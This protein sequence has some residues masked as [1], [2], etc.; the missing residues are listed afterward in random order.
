MSNQ[1]INPIHSS[2]NQPLLENTTFYDD[3]V[4]I[5]DAANGYAKIIHDKLTPSRLGS[6]MTPADIRLL[7]DV[8][9]HPGDTAIMLR[10]FAPENLR[11]L[12][13][14]HIY[15]C[16][17]WEIVGKVRVIQYVMTPELDD[18]GNTVQVY[19]TFR[20]I[21]EEYELKSSHQ[22]ALRELSRYREDMNRFLSAV[23]CGIIQYTR[24]SKQLIYINEFALNILGYHSKE[25]VLADGFNGI[26]STVDPDD[27]KAIR[28]LI[29]EK[30]INDGD[31][32]TYEYSVHH[33][34]GRPL[35]CYGTAQ[36][37]QRE[38]AEPIIQRSV[39]DITEHRLQMAEREA[40]QR[41][42]VEDALARAEHANRAKTA[43]L[44]SMSHD[45]RTPMNAIIGYTTL[46]ISHLD[47]KEKV[48]DY[49]QKI[50]SSSDHLL[51]LINDVL[52]MSR[53]EAGRVHLQETEESLPE[54]MNDL[55]ELLQNEII[56]KQLHFTYETKNI[57]DQGIYCDQLRLNQILLNCLTNSIKYTPTYGTVSLTVAQIPCESYEHATY[58][59]R[60]K[61]NGIGMSPEFAKHIFEPFTRENTST[62]SGIQGT[63]LGMTIT[64][65][66]VSMM[67]GDITVVSEKGVGTEFIIELTFLKTDAASTSADN[68]DQ[69]TAELPTDLNGIRIL[70]AEDNELNMEIAK[71]LLTEAGAQ[72]DTVDDGSLAVE[73]VRT[74][75]TGQYDIVLMDIQ[76][77]IMDGYTATGAIRALKGNPN[78]SLP[79]LAM[80]ANAFNEDKW[81]AKEAGMNGHLSKP[82]NIADVIRTI[83]E[84]LGY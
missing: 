71:E 46:A 51:A 73:A 8:N 55:R 18:S 75:T 42:L 63:G 79:I 13:V 7:L 44:N 45:I 52:D 27:A 25:E 67:G 15:T 21:R 28:Q 50:Q 84:V 16:R 6:V 35:V 36:L 19:T 53:I 65:N 61:D 80:T 62:V 1:G 40:K 74:A 2:Y 10:D 59:F 31:K 4:W 24:E 41:H 22:R 47:E 32:V 69:Q 30:L 9:C 43:F 83:H 3:A 66:L 39:I 12:K 26:V 78:A 49:L 17:P 77:P 64:K 34:D 37:I 11:K 70:L 68:A 76:M 82:F 81:R 20:N 14:T 23:S 5:L 56:K 33:R 38:G 54:L 29:D 48:A 57:Q 60:I 72:V 58:E